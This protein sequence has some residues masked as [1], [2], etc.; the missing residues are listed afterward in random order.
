MK[1][2]PTAK[3]AP[4]VSFIRAA[5]RSILLRNC[6]A[7][8]KKRIV[9]MTLLKPLPVLDRPTHLRRANPARHKSTVVRGVCNNW[10]MFLEHLKDLLSFGVTRYFSLFAERER[11]TRGAQRSERDLESPV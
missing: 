5:K 8:Q 3:S 9:A 2:V 4:S 1:Y 7:F 10:E 11:G 6:G